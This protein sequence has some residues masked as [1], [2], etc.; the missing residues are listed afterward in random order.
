MMAVF[1]TCSTCTYLNGTSCARY[2]PRPVVHHFSTTGLSDEEI[3]ER[4]TLRYNSV[5][6]PVVD[7]DNDWCG[8]YVPNRELLLEDS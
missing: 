1:L 7:G 8:E 5:S 2:A 3:D 4:M 6:W